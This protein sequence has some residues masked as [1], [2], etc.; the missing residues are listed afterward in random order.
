MRVALCWQGPCRAPRFLMVTA[1]VRGRRWSTA[2]VSLVGRG[3][4]AVLAKLVAA[5]RSPRSLPVAVSYISP[6]PTT[7]LLPARTGPSA[8]AARTSRRGAPRPWLPTA[9]GVFCAGSPAAS[10]GDS[11]RLPWPSHDVVSCVGPVALIGSFHLTA[12]M[13]FRRRWRLRQ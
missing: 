7:S 9:N 13:L 3:R 6:P 11:G 1:G 4:C 12:D 5:A 2:E 10:C 8:C